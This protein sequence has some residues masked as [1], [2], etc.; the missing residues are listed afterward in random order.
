MTYSLAA[1]PLMR[2]SFADVTIS[3]S[4][5]WSRKKS[6]RRGISNQMSYGNKFAKRL[7]IGMA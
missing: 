6:V 1:S 4:V 2:N 5:H 3:T 7:Y